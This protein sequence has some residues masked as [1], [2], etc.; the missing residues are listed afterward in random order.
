MTEGRT[1]K[2]CQNAGLRFVLFYRV[3]CKTL[4]L[5]ECESNG[6]GKTSLAVSILW[7]LTGNIDPRPLQD[8]KVSDVIHDT[9][10]VS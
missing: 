10:K 8:S 3:R 1:G 2:Q 4:I 9:S 5:Y 6:S 7:A